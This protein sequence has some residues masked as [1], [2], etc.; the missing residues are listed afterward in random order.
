MLNADNSPLSKDSEAEQEHNHGR[1]IEGPWIF[2][3][4]QSSDC[5]Y[6]WVERRD[7]NTLIPTIERNVQI[8]R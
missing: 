7:R 1:R 5:R 4:K 8:V 3:L 2:G 6:F